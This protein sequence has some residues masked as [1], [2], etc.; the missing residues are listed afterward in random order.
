MK[1]AIYQESRIG[2]RKYNQDRVGHAYTRDSLLMIIADG[3]GG[4]LHGEVAAQ[5][6]VE[7]F[8]QHFQQ[9]AN[10]TLKSPWQF[11][12]DSALRAHDGIL[13]YAAKHHMM[14]APRTTFVAVIIQDGLA[15]WAHV[16]DSRFYLF[17]QNTCLA[18]TRDHSKVRQM[19]ERGEI[20]EAM[21]EVHPERNRL[22]N[23][24][25]SMMIPDV[26]LGGKVP[27]MTGDTLLLCSDGLW[28]VVP[29]VE[30][31]RDMTS[32][33]IQ[34]GLPQLMDKAEMAAGASCD[35]VSAIALTW[36]ED[37]QTSTQEAVSTHTLPLDSVTTKFDE[38]DI[39]R[40]RSEDTDIS[41]DEIE[42]AISEIHETLKKYN[43]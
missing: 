6:T 10:P 19:V 40:L 41:D 12:K 31:V 17:R 4:H 20:T 37:D 14:E 39:A 13:S 18:Q 3:M 35:N 1:F 11:L 24:L 9:K 25:G 36:L 23:C 2:R 34:Y 5:I 42:R 15:Y 16:G 30:L 26:E 43:R 21:A 28:G 29:A 8:V 7:L 33:P 32:Y 38:L 22:Y 27:V